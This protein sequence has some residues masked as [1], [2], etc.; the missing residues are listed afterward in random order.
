MSELLLKY[1]KTESN[2]HT[3]SDTYAIYQDE[4]DQLVHNY[5]SDVEKYKKTTGVSNWGGYDEDPIAEYL[6]YCALLWFAKM[7]V[8][9][10]QK[11]QKELYLI[12]LT[13]V[14]TFEGNFQNS[15]SNILIDFNILNKSILVESYLSHN[16]VCNDFIQFDFDDDLSDTLCTHLSI[17]AI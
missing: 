1:F 17:F 13:P 11:M 6:Y 7:R 10:R 5:K 2:F 14:A 4:Y 3:L 16:K 15:D 9:F 12:W 8:Q